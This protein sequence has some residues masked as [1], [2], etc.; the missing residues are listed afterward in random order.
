MDE[1]L[2]TKEHTDDVKI[3]EDGVEDHEI[4]DDDEPDMNIINM[5]KVRFEM[6]KIE[7]N[8]Q[9]TDNAS[10]IPTPISSALN[11]KHKNFTNP[12]DSSVCGSKVKTSN[13]EIEK[14]TLEQMRERLL[15][16]SC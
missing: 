15:C 8:Q 4:I 12:E 1:D 13:I 16:I 14:D 2:D 5:N 10:D 3:D 6:K 9:T 7:Q 11:S